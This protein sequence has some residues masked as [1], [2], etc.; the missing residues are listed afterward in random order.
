M[1]VVPG[2]SLRNLHP[3]VW[4][5][6]S[7]Y[8]LP[9][10]RAIMVSYG[11]FHQMPM[12]EEA[13][14]K[15]GLRKFLSAPAHIRIFL[16]NGAFYFA[17]KKGHPDQ[18]KYREFIRQAKP[19]WYPVRF[20]AIPIPQ[21]NAR[22]QRACYEQTMRFNR[23]YQHDGYVPVIHVCSLLDEY[24]EALKRNPQLLQKKSLALGGMV[25]NLLRSPKALGYD[26]ILSGLQKVR[27]EFPKKHLHVFGIGGTAT[28]HLAYLLGV[29]SIDSSGWRNRAARGIVQLPGTGDRSA[30]K[31]GNWRGRAPNKSEW[32]VLRNCRCP[33]CKN[34]G[35]RGLKRRGI[36]GFCN[37]ATHNLYVLLEEASWLE[38]QTEKQSYHRKFK[39]RLNNSIY[40]PLLE[41][42]VEARS[43]TA[44]QN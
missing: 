30:V 44:Q 5:P 34:F 9:A 43:K 13:A 36:G 21:M 35:V 28:L 40:L 38:R 3:R 23:A 22:K 10:L 42:L 17:R 12:H 27:E 20:D 39:S 32:D 14:V 18:R 37:R 26:K 41:K 33:A 19:Y 7:P 31:F 6:N 24:V 8:Y 1:L 25:P 16:D 2:L 11:D 15:Q 4:D 29:D